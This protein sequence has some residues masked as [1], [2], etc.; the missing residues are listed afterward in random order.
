M[1]RII[2]R[3][4]PLVFLI[5]CLDRVYFDVDS[6][7]T[8]GISINGFVSDEIGPYRIE[9]NE[10]AAIESSASGKPVSCVVSIFD[11][12][13]NSEQLNEVK[14]GIYETS[15]LGLKGKIGNVYK[16]KV[17]L[18]DG[19]VFESVPDTLLSNGT[20]DSLFYQFVEKKNQDGVT[21]YGFKILVNSSLLYNVPHYMWTMTGT[22]KSDTRPELEVG[23]CYI[24]SNGVCNYIDPCTGLQNIGT[25]SSPNL[26]RISPCE[27]CTCWYDFSNSQVILSSEYLKRGAD[28][29]DKEIYYLDIDG[30]KFMYQIKIVASMRSLTYQSY[31]FWKAIKDQQDGTSSLFQ[32][33]I[34]KI[35][36]N[37]T[38]IAGYK[39]QV[40]GLFYAT[41]ISKK[42]IYM[43]RNS[44]PSEGFIPEV[45]PTLA[46]YSCLKLFQNATNKK[47]LDWEE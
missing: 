11:N 5:S 47:P 3:F 44:V 28:L 39:S 26:V 16:A 33:V 15:F 4:I 29:K 8:N 14:P 40:Q 18:S 13:G 43:T 25:N 32:P 22:F 6:T 46:S 19:R 24:Q 1:L 17:E 41:S 37:F 30:W 35:P 2:L 31:R 27:C 12:K 10:L 7:Q 23:G 38:Q 34:G 21:D 20:L 42:T 36:S 9:V 45:D